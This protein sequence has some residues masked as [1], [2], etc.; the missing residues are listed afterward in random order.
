MNINKVKVPIFTG[1]MTQWTHDYLQTSSRRSRANNGKRPNSNVV[2]HFFQLGD[3]SRYG[4]NF[5]KDAPK[6]LTI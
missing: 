1:K 4:V 6:Q 5:L 3:Q 2:I